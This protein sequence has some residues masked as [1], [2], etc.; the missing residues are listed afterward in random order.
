VALSSDIFTQVQQLLGSVSAEEAQAHIERLMREIHE[1]Q[2]E[3][4]R[5]YSL[6][7]LKSQLGE[8]PAP[9]TIP[10]VPPLRPAIK[11]VFRD[12]GVGT[13]IALATLRDELARR[14]W[15]GDGDTEY[16]R[17]QMMASKMAKR[18][19]LDRPQKG[20]YRLASS[21]AQSEEALNSGSG[22]AR[23]ALQSHRQPPGLGPSEASKVRAS[24]PSTVL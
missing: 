3:Q 8:A 13:V 19:E 17:L 21:V 5:W 4:Q 12:H 20:L 2:E 16:H 24:E 7:A 11:L 9:P 15:L 18:G 10:D 1:R 23:A 14:G 6:L 22:E